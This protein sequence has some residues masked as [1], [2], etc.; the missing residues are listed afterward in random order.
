MRN[1]PSPPTAPVQPWKWPTRPWARVHLD[2]AGPF[3]GRMF[4]KA[5][6]AHSKWM[7]VDTM[8]STTSFQKDGIKHT[9][10]TWIETKQAKQCLTPNSRTV[11]NYKLGDARNFGCG[12]RWIPWIASNYCYLYKEAP[13]FDSNW[14]KQ[15]QLAPATLTTSG[16]PAREMSQLP[17]RLCEWSH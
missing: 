13:F 3:L 15:N 2:Y 17:T 11:P 8:S 1:R 9:T 4:L 6:D 12:S 5:I 10:S 16:F 14:G 7:E